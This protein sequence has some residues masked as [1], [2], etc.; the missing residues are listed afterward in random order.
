M[1]LR[2]TIVEL[3]DKNDGKWTW[4]Q[5]E[6]GL[7]GVGLGGR[8]DAVATLSD[9]VQ[10]GALS[11]QTDPRY[12]HPIYRITEKG[13]LLMAQLTTESADPKSFE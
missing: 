11:E 12:M 6:R 4:Y 13:K 3:I 2:R 8:S 5:L 1:N 10:E 7:T 9:L